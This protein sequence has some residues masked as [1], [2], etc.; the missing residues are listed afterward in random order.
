MIKYSQCST[1]HSNELLQDGH[2]CCEPRETSA[3]QACKSGFAS[4]LEFVRPAT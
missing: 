2:R 4:G 1:L 3:S